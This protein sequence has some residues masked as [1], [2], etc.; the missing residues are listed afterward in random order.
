MGQE[1]QAKEATIVGMVVK[2]LQKVPRR[3]PWPES[4]VDYEHKLFIWKEPMPYL[5]QLPIS[6]LKESNPVNKWSNCT[7]SYMKSERCLVSF[8]CHRLE[9]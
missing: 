8:V 2:A 7:L 9:G 3:N 5:L 4:D 1:E 6:G